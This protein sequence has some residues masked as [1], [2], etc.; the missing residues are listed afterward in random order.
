M[1]NIKYTIGILFLMLVAACQEETYEFGDLTAPSNLVIDT[2]IVGES[3]ENPDGDGTGVVTITVNAQNAITYRIGFNKL[4]DYGNVSYSALPTGTISRKFTEPGVNT[5][6]ISV[7]AFGKGGVSSNLTKDISVRSDFAADPAIVSALTNDDSKTWVVDKS[8]AGHLGVGPWTPNSVTPEWYSAGIDEK[9]GIADC[10]YS[11]QFTFTKVSVSDTYTLEV[12]SPEGAFT[13]T[14]DLAGGLPG[15]PASG[16]E[17]C[18]AF[19][20]NASAFSFAPASSGVAGTTPSTQTSIQLGDDNTF[21]GY[22]AT[23]NEYEIL[24]ITPTYMHL[25]VQGTETGNA[26]YLK[27]VPA[28]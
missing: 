15:I 25:R 9:V 18:Y 2:D 20:G 28:E 17:G 7:I 22:G 6:R 27:L 10:L 4:S 14:G 23:L 3:A 8:V 24:E 26:W 12:V 5:Y 21:I 19:G 13:K 11:A 16:E 1:K